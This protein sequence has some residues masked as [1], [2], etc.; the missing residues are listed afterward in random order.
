MD[1]FIF[2]EGI[3]EYKPET[4][5][6]EYEALDCVGPF[7]EDEYSEF[8]IKEEEDE[9]NKDRKKESKNKGNIFRVS[10]KEIIDSF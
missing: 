6:V 9:T 2:L 10:L 4:K 1:F 3:S 7:D 5:M 8:I